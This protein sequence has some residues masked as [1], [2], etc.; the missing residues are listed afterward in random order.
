MCLIFD[1]FK[2]TMISTIGLTQGK[3]IQEIK[4]KLKAEYKPILV[5]NYYVWPAV[6]LANFYMVPL[7]YQVLLVQF[8]AIFWNTFISFKTNENES[9]ESAIK[10]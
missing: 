8:V 9:T 6:Q 3:S 7:N 1:R 10:L 2:G 5:T 4:Q